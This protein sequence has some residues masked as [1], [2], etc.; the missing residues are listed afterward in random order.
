MERKNGSHPCRIVFL[1]HSLTPLRPPRQDPRSQ[2]QSR[3]PGPNRSRQESPRRQGRA[4]EG[5]PR[6]HRPPR[7][8]RPHPRGAQARPGR[9]EGL[10]LGQAT[11]PA[12]EWGAA[13]G[14]ESPDDDDAGRVEQVGCGA[15]PSGGVGEPDVCVDV[16][17]VRSLLLVMLGRRGLI[18]FVCRKTYGPGD[19]GKTLGEL[20]FAPRYGLL[21]LPSLPCRS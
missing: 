12:P 13:V 1:P 8:R 16:P 20:G 11:D 3:R 6:R 17:E 10:R 19:L 21:S 5:P 14:D 18:G 9:E 2:S 7:R 15:A 4:R